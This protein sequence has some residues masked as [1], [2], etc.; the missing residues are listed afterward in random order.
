MNSVEQIITEFAA[1]V[2]EQ[3]NYAQPSSLTFLPKYA[4]PN[5]EGLRLLGSGVQVLAAWLLAGRVQGWQSRNPIFVLGSRDAEMDWIAGALRAAGIEYRWGARVDPNLPLG[6]RPVAPGETANALLQTLTAGGLSLFGLELS[7]FIGVEVA[8]NNGDGRIIPPVIDHHA[9]GDPRTEAP[10]EWAWLASSAGQIAYILTHIGQMTL[11]G[12]VE[13][14]LVGESD[15]NLPAFCRGQGFT[16][17]DL[18]R[19][20]ALLTRWAAFGDGLTFEEFTAA[21]DQ[22]VSTL[23]EAAGLRGER[24]GGAYTP[25]ADLRTLPI[26]GPVVKATGEQYP[27]AAQFLP[28]AASISGIGYLVHIRRRDGKLALRIGGLPPGHLILRYFAEHPDG[29]GC[30]P[31]DAPR[32]DN[33]YAFPARGMGGGTLIDQGNEK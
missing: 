10:P 4:R 14:V 30:L 25:V 16:P 11:R 26:D 15:H 28:V 12:R 8:L 29:F 1:R 13:A 2:V 20:Y 7:G 33:A 27:A 32:P 6:F 9:P 23:N 21:V 5:D 24:E 31:A 3:V 22:A 18:A 19:H 17:A